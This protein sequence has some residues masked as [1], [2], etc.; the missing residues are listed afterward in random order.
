MSTNLSKKKSE[1]L[2]QKHCAYDSWARFLKI[3]AGTN[4]SLKN[5]R[6]HI[7]LKKSENS[8]Q[9]HFAYDSWARGLQSYRLAELESEL[10]A[11]D[12]G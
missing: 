1:N 12:R 11:R 4:L 10:D 6:V 8:S 7:S 2:S 3:E 5:S 9:K